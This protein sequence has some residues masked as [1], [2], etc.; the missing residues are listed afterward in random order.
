M[1]EDYFVNEALGAL[2]ENF[3]SSLDTRVK[4]VTV[5]MMVAANPNFIPLIYKREKGKWEE[6]T[7]TDRESIPWENRP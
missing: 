4:L 3:E 5:D 2:P 7:F 6:I 1:S